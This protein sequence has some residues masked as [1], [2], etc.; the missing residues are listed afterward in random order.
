MSDRDMRLD[1][2]MQVC[3]C[4]GGHLAHAL[5]AVLGARDNLRVFVLTRRPAQW[6]SEIVAIYHD[7]IEL[8]GRIEGASDDPQQVIPG[9]RA[10]IFTVPAFAH[11]DIVVRIEPFL[12]PATWL[13]A[14]PGGGFPWLL[15]RHLGHRAQ[16]FGVQR[17]PYVCRITEYG[18]SVSITGIRKVLK[19]GARP[20]SQA[21]DVGAWLG[22]QLNMPVR[23]IDNYLGVVLGN[24]NAVFHSARLY[25]LFKPGAQAKMARRPRFYADWD[26]PASEVYLACDSEIQAL[27]RAIPLDLSGVEPVGAHF[28]L[29]EASRED[30]R[31]LTR[32]IRCIPALRNIPAPVLS[33][34]GDCRP[35]L[36]SRFF[37]EDM[38]YGLL[39][40]RAVAQLA[41]VET[42][43]ID[44]LLSWA[45]DLLGERFL[46]GPR[47]A[48]EGLMHLPLPQSLGMTR[49]DD[50]V[51]WLTS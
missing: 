33:P 12:T 47:L 42:P 23:A 49:L 35:D 46:L 51:S 28:E 4:G 6:R 32:K 44:E 15:D 43:A 27:C 14:M 1:D 30:A 39:P 8:V 10:V 16:V 40:I 20:S 45:Q 2:D 11:Q 5:A 41:G 36:T 13:G 24:G 7:E 17:A 50:L 25:S 31:A 19:L 48:L 34:P 38:P 37:R 3:I 22:R 9:S 21:R 26:L 29:P 18:K